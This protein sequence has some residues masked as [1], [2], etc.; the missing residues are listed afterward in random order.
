MIRIESYQQWESSHEA[1]QS[2]IKVIETLE[3]KAKT[4]N[5]TNF[6][7]KYQ[8]KIQAIST[9]EEVTAVLPT[10]WSLRSKLYD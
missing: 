8:E 2:K 7:I 10:F 4:R 9:N 1:D 6:K 5:H 3:R